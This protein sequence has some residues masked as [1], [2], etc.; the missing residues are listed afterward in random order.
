MVR[1]TLFAIFVWVLQAPGVGT[2]SLQAQSP[3]VRAHVAEIVRGSSDTPDGRGLLPVAMAEVE[4]ADRHVRLSLI[5]NDL[6]SL[7]EIQIHNR[8]VIHALDPAAE[9]QGPGAGYGL[10]P[11]LEGIARHA[12]LIADADGISEAVEERARDVARLAAA[13]AED[14]RELLQGTRI[15]DDASGTADVRAIVPQMLS[16]S[17][18][19][20]RDVADLEAAVARLVEVAGPA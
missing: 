12:G 19:I 10:V 16:G 11:A 9:P 15:I 13:A 4:T 6:S 5:E 1:I 17:E 8:H 2:A 18:Q 14:A 20:V 7:D 3:D